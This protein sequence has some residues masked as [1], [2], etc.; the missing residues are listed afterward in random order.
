MNAKPTRQVRALIAA[1]LVALAPAAARA[2][3]QN[4]TTDISV[5]EVWTADNEYVLTQPIYVRDGA[6]LTIE[7]GTVIRG[8]T[9]SGSGTNDPGTLIITRGSKIVANGTPQELKA[10]SELA[11]AVHLRVAG[12][13]PAAIEEQCA[14][15]TGAARVEILGA[16]DGKVEARVYAGHAQAGGALTRGVAELA[17][18]QGWRLDEIHTEEGRLDE[19]FRAITLPDTV[20]TRGNT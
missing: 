20:K 17:A 10:R 12:V 15:L 13:P 7:P 11:G 18:Q 6:T 3:V 16:T 8:E 5:S 2:A 9:E 19:V 4:V 1:A 14:R